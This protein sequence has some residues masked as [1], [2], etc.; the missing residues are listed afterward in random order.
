MSLF[1]YSY[2][3]EACILNINMLK[4][5]KSL[6]ISVSPLDPEAYTKMLRDMFV[7]TLRGSGYE[8]W[9][10][11]NPEI[12]ALTQKYVTFII[13]GFGYKHLHIGGGKWEKVDKVLPFIHQLLTVELPHNR[14]E[15]ISEGICLTN[16]KDNLHMQS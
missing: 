4:E 11:I 2:S 6:N 5:V 8:L 14:I 7:T 3:N 12:S 9:V 16:H 10:D 1:F 13:E 15:S